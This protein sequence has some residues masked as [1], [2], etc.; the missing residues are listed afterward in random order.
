MLLCAACVVS[1][2]H[3]AKNEDMRGETALL[4]LRRQLHCAAYNTLVAVISCVQTDVK[5]YN[6][7]LFSDDVAKVVRHCRSLDVCSVC[8][9]VLRL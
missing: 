9:L 2:G 1:A 6:G 7:F 4:E 5:F 8:V 3:S